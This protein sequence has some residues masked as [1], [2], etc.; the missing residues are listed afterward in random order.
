MR[1][2]RLT[3]SSCSRAFMRRLI[4][5]LETPRRWAAAVKLRVS[6][7]TASIFRSASRSKAG[8]LIIV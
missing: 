4:R 1:S 8:V 7:N 6:A 3:P 5:D 2:S